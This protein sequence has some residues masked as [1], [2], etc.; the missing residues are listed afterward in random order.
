MRLGRRLREMFSRLRK[1][2]AGNIAVIS[3]LVL[4]ALVGLFGLGT[5]AGYWYFRQR[6]MQ[7]AADVTAYN[8][9]AQLRNG[10]SAATIISGA[11]SDAVTNGWN[12]GIGSITVHTPPTSGNHINGNSVEVI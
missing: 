1:S 4:P 2:E 7:A 8:A 6:T 9:T 5:D 12:S 3:A 10:T 11:S